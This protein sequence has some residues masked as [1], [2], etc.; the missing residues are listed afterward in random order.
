MKEYK[1][2]RD[3]WNAIAECKTALEIKALIE[4][5]PRWSGD[6]DLEVGE[7]DELV[8]TNTGADA[9]TEY[10]DI[11][12]KSLEVDLTGFEDAAEEDLLDTLYH[13]YTQEE[14]EMLGAFD[15]MSEADEDLDI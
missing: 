11:T 2:I 1:H 9:C 4:T 14:L 15:N 6:W 5:F 7:D 3:C 10:C 12:S 8:V 13:D